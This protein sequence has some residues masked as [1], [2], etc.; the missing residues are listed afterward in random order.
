MLGSSVGLAFREAGASCIGFDIDSDVAA[1]SM[2]CGA[3]ERVADSVSA[4]ADV[5]VVMLAA[6]VCSVIE[7]IP[8]IARCVRRD[9]LV[10]DVASTKGA[11]VAAMEVATVESGFLGFVGGHPMAGATAAGPESAHPKRFV[12]ASWAVVHVPGADP[13]AASR[14]VGIVEALGAVPLLVSAADHD[15]AVARSSHLPHFAAAALVL[16]ALEP[17]SSEKQQL[18]RS[19]SASGWESVTHLADGDTAMWR[20][21]AIT[22]RDEI[23]ASIAAMQHELSMLAAILDKPDVV[24]AWLQRA[25]SARAAGRP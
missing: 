17:H 22:N 19:L 3:I 5:D 13:S 9:A 21:I 18:I 20:D 24:Q 8:E 16:G 25:K 23:A 6:P 4:V 11:I 10:T 14:L 7:L 1:R 2:R 12:N 15:A